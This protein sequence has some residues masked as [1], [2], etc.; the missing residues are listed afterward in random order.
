MNSRI[1]LS[2][3]KLEP[4]TTIR[5][6]SKLMK[7][8]GIDLSSTE[9]CT[10]V[11]LIEYAG[12]L[13]RCSLPREQCSDGEI[14]T[15][16]K[17]SDAV[18]IDA[19]LGWPDKFTKAVSE[20]SLDNWNTEIRDE[21]RFRLTDRIVRER[22][23]KWPLSVSSDLIALPAMR[24][25]ALLRRSN[26]Q[27][28]S[29]GDKGFYEVY[30]AGS[31]RIWG[32]YESGYKKSMEVRRRMLS[33]LR[34][35]FPLLEIPEEY[36]NTDDNLDSLVAAITVEQAARGITIAPTASQLG[37]AMNEGWIHLPSN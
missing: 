7:A 11:C 36:A 9:K 12:S 15:L 27:D 8:L 28:K 18:G 23:G 34:I 31:L 25:M 35:N 37:L 20:W 5:S 29:G 3:I 22:I 14:D 24:A 30:P 10:S 13:G 2:K 17:D 16:T 6:S 19:P 32:I 4:E 21:L 1:C 33:A 26:V